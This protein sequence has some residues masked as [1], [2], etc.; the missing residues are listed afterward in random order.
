MQAVKSE[1]INRAKEQGFTRLEISAYRV[2]GANPNR[3]IDKS[4]DLTK[5]TAN[6][7]KEFKNHSDP[8]VKYGQDIGRLEALQKP[9]KTNQSPEIS[10]SKLPDNFLPS[11]DIEK[12]KPDINKQPDVNSRSVETVGNQKAQQESYKEAK[13][14]RQEKEKPKDR[15]KDK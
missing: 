1:F 12:P 13:E 3:Q 14:H 7:V 4:I 8:M 5:D 6:P 11:R 2:S 10:S 15:D 9:Y